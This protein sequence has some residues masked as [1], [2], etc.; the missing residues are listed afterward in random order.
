MQM[1][2]LCRPRGL[3]LA[4]LSSYTVLR[5]S[6]LVDTASQSVIPIAVLLHHL[7][8]FNII[9]ILGTAVSCITRKEREIGIADPERSCLKPKSKES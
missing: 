4:P 6:P 1:V 2:A 3:Q 5:W 8:Q 7:Q 9:I